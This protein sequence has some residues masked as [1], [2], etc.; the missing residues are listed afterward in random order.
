MTALAVVGGL[1]FALAGPAIALTENSELSPLF[2]GSAGPGDLGGGR[3]DAP[4]PAER[5]SRSR[6]PAHA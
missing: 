6:R 5:I 4:R 2:A 3:G 1:A